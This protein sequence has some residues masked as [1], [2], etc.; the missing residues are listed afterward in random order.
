[1]VVDIG[2]GTTDV[3]LLSLGET[4]VTESVRVGG[5]KFDEAIARYIKRE[6]NLLI[7][8]RTAEA[9]KVEVGTAYSGNRLREAEVRGRDM[10]SG[11]PRSFLVTTDH[12]LEAMQEPL[13]DILHCIKRL[14]ERTPPELAGDIIEH[15][16]VMTGGGS[17]LDGLDKRFSE[18]TGVLC[19]V[20]EDAVACVAKG[21]GYVL[22]HLEK[23]VHTLISPKR[24]SATI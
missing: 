19:Y 20:A 12:V 2:G 13:D 1:M 17:L 22:E 21:T 3:A 23:L 9:L 18:E 5:D 6:F 24:L 4:V 8:E 14:L 7:G 16:I 10:I 11:L 15:G